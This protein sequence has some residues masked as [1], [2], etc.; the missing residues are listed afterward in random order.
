MKKRAAIIGTVALLA[1]GFLLLIGIFIL[2]S[3]FSPSIIGKCVGVIN[4]DYPLDTRGLPPTLF[5]D[6]YPSSEALAEEIRNM[7]KREDVGALLLVVD[8]PGGSVV[9][10]REVYDAI[11]EFKKPKVVYIREMAA[12]GGYYI[13]TAAD[14]IVAHPDAIVGNIGARATFFEMEG[15]LSKLGVEVN[16]IKS[17]AHKDLGSPFRNMTDEERAIV[18]Q[19]VDETYEEFKSAVLEGRKGKIDMSRFDEITD[20]RIMSG[21]KAAKYG[22][23]DETGDK[24]VALRKAADLA[25]LQYERTEDIRTCPVELSGEDSAFINAR[26]MLNFLGIKNGIQYR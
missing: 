11:K 25:N 2:I 12:S 26:A 13:A 15:L 9:A 24:R 18:Q 10:T 14:Y 3:L 17:G 5:D 20:G 7:D 16:V 8:T 4:V 23:V 6:G 21:R 19:L 22:L 1:I